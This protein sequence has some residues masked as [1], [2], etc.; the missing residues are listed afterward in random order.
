MIGERLPRTTADRVAVSGELWNRLMD[1]IERLERLA[2]TPP[3][4]LADNGAGRVLSLVRQAGGGKVTRMKVTNAA[5]G[6]ANVMLA[7][8]YD[9][10]ATSGSDVPV[11]IVQGHPPGGEL[12]A[13]PADGNTDAAYGG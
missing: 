6:G 9:G 3:L 10:T 2:V 4:M 1:R 12:Y 7:K 8:K 5:P 11:R 13:I